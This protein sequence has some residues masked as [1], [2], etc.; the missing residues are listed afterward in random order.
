MGRMPWLVLLVIVIMPALEIGLF[1]WTG[2]HIGAG[3]VVALIFLTGIAGAVLARRQGME[4]WRRARSA[5]AEGRVPKEEI[6]D[7]ICVLIGGIFLIAPGF[8]TDALGVVLLLPMT[9]RPLKILIK[10]WLVLL[11]SKK[12]VYFFRR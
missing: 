11:I 5:M 9:R 7:G 6:L 8:I 1:I 3:W 10:K 4:T 12:G 2:S